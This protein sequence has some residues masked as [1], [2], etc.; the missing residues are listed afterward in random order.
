MIFVAVTTDIEETIPQ[1][2]A[3]D[4]CQRPTMSEMSV[5][6]VV[7]F[8]LLQQHT[9]IHCSFLYI[10]TQMKHTQH[11]HVKIYSEPTYTKESRLIINVTA[12]KNVKMDHGNATIP[13]N[14]KHLCYTCVINTESNKDYCKCSICML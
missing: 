1:T 14:Q 9:N 7:A 13:K 10:T 6:Q 2:H 4:Q 11:H 12:G 8:S 3:D 5:S